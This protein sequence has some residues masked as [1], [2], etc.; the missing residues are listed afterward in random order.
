M[1]CKDSNN[2]KMEL[3]NIH[4]G[5]IKINTYKTSGGYEVKVANICGILNIKAAPEDA[6]ARLYAPTIEFT[7]KE[8]GSLQHP[9]LLI[10]KELSKEALEYTIHAT[11]LLEYL[12][13]HYDELMAQ[14]E[15]EIDS[16]EE[17]KA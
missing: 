3:V 13:N 5:S 8:C 12:Y 16:L 15:L 2:I 17:E 4:R 7:S 11:Y 14:V 1:K 9:S 10:S 6:S